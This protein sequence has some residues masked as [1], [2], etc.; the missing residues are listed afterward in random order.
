MKIDHLDLRFVWD[1]RDATALL[2]LHSTTGFRGWEDLDAFIIR[3]TGRDTRK[4]P[5]KWEDW[6]EFFMEH[7]ELLKSI[8]F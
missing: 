2:Q 7:L 1:G 8:T 5:L 3:K 4:V 6:Y